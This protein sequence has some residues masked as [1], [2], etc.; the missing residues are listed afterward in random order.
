MPRLS[1]T[2]SVQFKC[3]QVLAVPGEGCRRSA[4]DLGDWGAPDTVI[5]LA[6]YPLYTAAVRHSVLEQ[7]SLARL[8]FQMKGERLLKD[9]SWRSDQLMPLASE[10]NPMVPAIL[11]KLRLIEDSNGAPEAEA[12]G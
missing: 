9:V 12:G 5:S 7:A 8:R 4:P 10:E 3:F 6:R 2:V 1:C 11:S